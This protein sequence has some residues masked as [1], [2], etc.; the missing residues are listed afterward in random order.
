ML[1]D[2][3]TPIFIQIIEKLKDDIL[4]GVYEA[5]ELIISTNQI[6]KLYSVNP[7]TAVKSVSILQDEEILY[8]KRGIGMRVAAQAKEKILK[9]RTERFFHQVIPQTIGEAK[10]IGIT[11]E[12]LIK[13][14][15]EDE[16]YD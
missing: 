13:V 4:T 9:E 12:Q 7:A 6:A 1:V 2:N 16:N 10:K 8:K 11:K 5:D 14:I 3:T 15:T